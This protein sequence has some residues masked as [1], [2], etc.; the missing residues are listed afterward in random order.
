MT[1]R[2]IIATEADRAQF[3]A[4]A[5]ERKS[6][7]LK[8]C[9][10]GVKLRYATRVLAMDTRGG[11]AWEEG[12][13]VY[14]NLDAALDDFFARKVPEP[15]DRYT[16]IAEVNFYVVDEDGDEVVPAFGF[17]AIATKGVVQA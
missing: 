10:G 8:E 4:Y 17:D 14:D 3:K 2:K 9:E 6:D 16:Y 13:R 12:V 5:A 7:V 11:D 15:R 1:M